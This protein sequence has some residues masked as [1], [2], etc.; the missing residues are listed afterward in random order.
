MEEDF[1]DVL[2][3]WMII[4]L[5]CVGILLFATLVI[6]SKGGFLLVP[7]VIL[8]PPFAYMKFMSWYK[9]KK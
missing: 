9:R 4:L 3:V 2:L 7:I 6:A 1:V 5:S 8:G